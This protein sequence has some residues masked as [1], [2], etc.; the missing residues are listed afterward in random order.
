MRTPACRKNAAQ[1]GHTGRRKAHLS[2]RV[3]ACH[4]GMP[5]ARRPNL[6]LLKHGLDGRAK[7]GFART[8]NIDALFRLRDGYSDKVLGLP[9]N[10][11]NLTHTAG[12][13]RQLRELRTALGYSRQT[14]L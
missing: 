11:G 8:D 12:S 5:S 3:H 6:A 13:Y 4:L 9:Q 2:R 10:T 1:L 7:G 14:D